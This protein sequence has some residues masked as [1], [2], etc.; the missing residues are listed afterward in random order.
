MAFILGFILLVSHINFNGELDWRCGR[1]GRRDV[2]QLPSCLVK[3]IHLPLGR[4]FRKIDERENGMSRVSNRGSNNIRLEMIGLAN[5]IKEK[6]ED[7]KRPVMKLTVIYAVAISALIRANMRYKDDVGR[8]LYGYRR[9]D[10]ASRYLSDLLS[11]ILH[12]SEKVHDISPLT[13]LIACLLIAIASAVLCMV[14]SGGK[15]TRKTM[16]ASLPMGLSCFF[17][18][19]FSFKYD[20]PY[21]ALSAVAAMLPFL[22]LNCSRFVYCSVSMIGILVACTTYQASLGIYPMMVIILFFKYWSTGRWTVKEGTKFSLIS[23]AVWSGTILFYRFVMVRKIPT[24]TSDHL[25]SPRNMLHGIIRNYRKYFKHIMS[26]YNRVWSVLMLIIIL[27]CLMLMIARSVRKLLPTILFAVVSLASMSLL[28][29]GVFI[30]METPR[31]NLRL[32]TG[33]G[34][35]TAIMMVYIT[36]GADDSEIKARKLSVIPIFA[37]MAFSWCMFSF[38][39]IYGNAL[40][41]QMQYTETIRTMLVNDLVHSDLIN[42]GNVKKIQIKKNIGRCPETKAA[43]DD[44]P[45]LDR[46]IPAT[47]SNY[48]WARPTVFNSMNIPNIQICTDVNLRKLGLPE[49]LDTAYY[50]IYGNDEYILAVMKRYDRD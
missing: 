32:M 20:S 10:A 19:C 25:L 34:Y 48:L 44:F 18:E 49:I 16:I 41:Y 21:M 7:L 2:C 42:S 11:M 26:D 6:Y 22:F 12:T 30:A 17:L 45:V 35:L 31:Y 8:T 33:F 37:S 13:Q 5:V 4:L 29:Y 36:G 50:T 46:L 43:V 38:S 47:L 39:F 14:I 23:A 40:N 24:Y 27:G 15:F 9:W 1:P 3:Y 28:C